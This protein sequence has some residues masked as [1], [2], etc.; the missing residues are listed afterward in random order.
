MDRWTERRM[1]ILIDGQIDEQM[2]RRN[3]GHTD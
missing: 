2:D 1:D 3:D